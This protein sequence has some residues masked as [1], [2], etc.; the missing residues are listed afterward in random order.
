MAETRIDG[1]DHASHSVVQKGVTF[2]GILYAGAETAANG[3]QPL[4]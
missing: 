4:E 3:V 1:G 2:P